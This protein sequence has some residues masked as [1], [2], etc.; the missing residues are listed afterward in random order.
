[1]N[2]AHAKVA[3][4]QDEVCESYKQ[5]GDIGWST[6]LSQLMTENLRVICY[7]FNAAWYMTAIYF[8]YFA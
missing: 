1:M 7:H 4:Q 3:Y 2:I 5:F 8:L 6:N